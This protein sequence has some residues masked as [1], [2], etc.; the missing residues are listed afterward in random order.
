MA[1]VSVTVLPDTA[2]DD[3][4]GWP[5]FSENLDAAGTLVVSKILVEGDHQR[6]FGQP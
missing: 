4:D 1:S 2:T 6:W 3:T 5:V